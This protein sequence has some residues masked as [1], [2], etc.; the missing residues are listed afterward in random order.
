MIVNLS[1]LPEESCH[2]PDEPHGLRGFSKDPGKALGM[3]QLGLDLHTLQ[4]GQENSRYHREW[5]ED[6]FFLV[7][8]GVCQL[9]LEGKLYTLET[10][11]FVYIPSG[12][13]HQFFNHSQEPCAIWMG[14]EIREG[15]G[16]DY[17][18]PPEKWEEAE[19]KPPYCANLAKLTPRPVHDDGEPA[20]CRGFSLDLGEA[21]GMQRIETCVHLLAPG[22]QDSKLHFHRQEEELFVIMAGHPVLRLNEQHIMTKPGD[23]IHVPPGARH[24]FLNP[25]QES[26]WIW[27]M[28]AV[29]FEP[30]THYVEED[31]HVGDRVGT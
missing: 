19:G 27:M 10:G 6:E 15:G 8:E 2:Y 24:Q 11:D 26:A 12:V 7:E 21:V 22:Q 18:D 30:D 20:G 14:G 16:A 28:N 9:R 13:A 1:Q 4:P 3:T 25:N 23:C 5:K 17:P 31:Q 29:S